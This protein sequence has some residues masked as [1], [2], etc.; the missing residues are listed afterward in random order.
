MG[1]GGPAQPG[2]PGVGCQCHGGLLKAGA[3]R[4][5]PGCRGRKPP[6]AGTVCECPAP[7]TAPALHPLP[8]LSRP[9][10][11]GSQRSPSWAMGCPEALAGQD[12]TEGPLSPSTSRTQSRLRPLTQMSLFPEKVSR[13]ART[14]SNSPAFCSSSAVGPAGRAL[15][16]GPRRAPPPQS[17]PQ[18]PPPRSVLR[19]CSP[20]PV[21]CPGPTVSCP[22][23][24]P[25]TRGP[26]PGPP[27]PAP[28][29]PR[30]GRAQAL[31][32]S[33]QGPGPAP[34]PC[35]RPHSGPELLEVDCKGL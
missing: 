2:A 31:L 32:L 18:A 30:L 1:P 6:R 4:K 17:R 14:C 23:W 20:E 3:A 35:G 34:A 19:H 8:L 28:P 12:E 5:T 33:L 16:L 9:R 25:E 15:E 26:L 10:L 22:A 24:D 13:C 27:V 11:R 29:I 7:R 21:T